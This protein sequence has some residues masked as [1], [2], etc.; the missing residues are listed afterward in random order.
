M[1]TQVDTQAVST[2]TTRRSTSRTAAAQPDVERAR[3]IRS[4]LEERLAELR[5]EYDLILVEAAALNTD[6]LGPVAGDDVA[7]VGTKTLAR[8]QE[9]ALANTIRGRMF[10]VERAL[11]RLAVGG[12]GSCETCT[13]PIPPARLAAFP[14]ATLCVG[15]KQRQ[16]R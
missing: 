6:G 4:A 11:E 10:Q 1:L 16:E 13:E 2:R 5:E 7:D 15:C 14:S 8:E 9:I 3:Q 12:Y